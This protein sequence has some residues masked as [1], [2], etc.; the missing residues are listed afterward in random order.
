MSSRR[1]AKVWQP[2]QSGKLI[3]VRRPF[4]ISRASY[5]IEVLSGSN[6]L[7]SRLALDALQGA[8]REILGRMLDRDNPRS[9]RMLEVVVRPFDASQPPTI[10]LEPADY[11]T[12]VQARASG[13]KKKCSK[14]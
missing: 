10:S 4:F 8:D 1:S 6:E 14:S 11:F 3:S 5:S 7:Y 13:D 2:G 9:C 12:G